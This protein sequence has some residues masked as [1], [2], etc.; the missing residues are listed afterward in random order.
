LL[1]GFFGG[2]SGGNKLGWLETI[3]LALQAFIK[4][5]D[6]IDKLTAAIEKKNF[7]NWFN[8][9]GEVHVLLSKSTT[10]EQ[11]IEAAKKIQNLH[12]SR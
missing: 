2:L 7:D 4:I 6:G 8:S 10:V 9:S 11:K 3:R 5:S 12:S 1:G